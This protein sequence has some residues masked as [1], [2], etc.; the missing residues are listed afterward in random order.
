M[1]IKQVW[2]SPNTNINSPDSIHQVLMYGSL[3][4][5][6]SLI[7]HLGTDHIRSVFLQ[8]PKKIYTNQAL[9]FIKK[10]VLKTKTSIDE[11]KYLKS[12]TRNL[13]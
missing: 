6:R 2:Y 11:Q 10:F 13:R 7:K 1:K 12:T 3:E 5:V 4:D 8:Y 9:N